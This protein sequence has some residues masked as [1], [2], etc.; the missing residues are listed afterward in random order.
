M[1]NDRGNIRVLSSTV[2]LASKVQLVLC[3]LVTAVKGDQTLGVNQPDHLA[4]LI[5]AHTVI[6]HKVCSQLLGNTNSCGTGTKE[7]NLVV[8]GRDAG[9]VDGVH[10][11]SKDN[12]TGTLD[13]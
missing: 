8:L 1:F 11:S 9:E 2:I 4:C 12:C 3:Q 7:N 5:L 6:I 10:E 13:V